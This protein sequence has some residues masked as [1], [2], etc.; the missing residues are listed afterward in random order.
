[1]VPVT[2]RAIVLIVAS[3][4]V[5]I[6][7]G[8]SGEAVYKQ[9]C[10]SCHDGASPRVPP[11][12]ALQRLS[13]ARI[14]RVLDFGTMISVGYLL[15]RD[16]RDAVSKY[17]G[18]PGAP[19][20]EPKS[21]AYCPDRTVRLSASPGA[22]TTWNSWSASPGNSRFQANGLTIDQTR[23]L[24]L[25]WAYGFEGDVIAFSQPTVID[26]TVFVG[27]ASGLVQALDAKTGCTKWTFQADGPVRAALTFASNTVLFGDQI[28]WYY[29]LNALT[30]KQVWRKKIETH[31]S[32]RLTGASTVY[33]GIVYVPVASWEET[34]ALNDGYE[35]CTFRGSIV[36]LRVSD[37]TQVW[38]SYMIP[39]APKRRGKNKLGVTMW[40][41]SGSGVWSAPTVDAKRG[42]LY[43]TTSDNYSEPA[44]KTS[45]AVLAVRIRDGKILWSQQKTADDV[46]N[47]Y[48]FPRME[49]PG[50]D[51]DFGSS[52]I[53]VTTE[54]GRDLILA[55]QKS[56]IV[57]ALDP[58]KQGAQ[59]WEARVG[60]GGV[61]GGVQWGMATDGQKVYAANSDV[62]RSEAA[63][64]DP[65]DPRPVPFDPKQGGGL[66][67]LRVTD[68]KREWYSA[69]IAC[70]ADAKP[71]C[72]P[73]QSAA[74]TAMPGVI[75]SAAL[76][77]HLRAFAS[78]DG[79]ML[80]DFDTMRPFETVNG[81]RASGGAIDGPGAVV[82]GGMV[83]VNSGYA[84]TGGVAG[85]V[86]LAFAPEE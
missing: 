38:K 85:N 36:A 68:G 15:K 5:A 45:D 55:G 39:E 21:S 7:Q 80:W 63:N 18:T 79:R 67:A 61:N 14:L 35:C 12:A 78:E 74:V 86:L 54:G 40:G 51:F 33:N 8:V 69:P 30:G 3:A 77:G 2:L 72:S 52:A 11:K 48:C 26:G 66:T 58:D 28:G 56:G 57:Y 1:M 41:P 65:N 24:K 31:E 37:G 10:A 46:F 84:R 9:R 43:V 32:T 76:D 17:L 23:K 53:L 82:A 44:T 19:S 4:A 62:G 29:A 27:S 22:G 64:P 71:G 83:F 25:K 34:R 60:K 16:E 81:V 6:A 13:S 50:M 47:G 70:G 20:G 49:C 59:V 42:V 73:A 75:F